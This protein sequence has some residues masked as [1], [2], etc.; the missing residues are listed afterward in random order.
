MGV[1]FQFFQLLPTLT[2][3][4]NVMLPMDFCRLYTPKERRER[5]MALLA[6]MWGLSWPLMK[7]ALTE[8]QPLRFRTF[9]VSAGGMGLLL[10]S[11]A[12]GYSLRFPMVVGP[13]YIPGTPAATAQ[14]AGWSPN[15]D[16][17][18]DAAR[19]TQIGRAHV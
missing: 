12:G 11:L 4:E 3:V 5:A 2:V 10:I 9:S 13:R 8:M 16:R 14:P 17:V 19:I 7:L 1:V 15:T 18:P 6:L